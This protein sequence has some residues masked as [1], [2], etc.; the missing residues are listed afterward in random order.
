MED[1]MFKLRFKDIFEYNEGSIYSVNKK[2]L[3]P[4][5][6]E[7]IRFSDNNYLADTKYIINTIE[8]M[9][10]YF[11]SD[12]Y[13]PEKYAKYR[14]NFLQCKK[15]CPKGFIF[16]MLKYF[17]VLMDGHMSVMP[18]GNYELDIN[19]DYNNNKL[20]FKNSNIILFEIGGISSDYLLEKVYEYFYFENKSSKELYIPEYVK[21]KIFLE[22]LGCNIVNNEISI[23]TSDGLKTYSFV[24][25]RYIPNK[26]VINSSIIGNVLYIDYRSCVLNNEFKNIINKIKTSIKNDINKVIIDVRN[27]IGGTAKANHE[28]FKALNMC[29]PFGGSLIRL[30]NPIKERFYNDYKFDTVKNNE[31][32]YT[33][34]KSN[35]KSVRR[36]NKIQLVVLVSKKTYSSAMLFALDVMDGNL[37]KVIGEIPSNAPCSFGEIYLAQTPRLKVPFNI[38]YKYLF[39]PNLRESFKELKP[40]IECA[41][42]KAL[43][44]ALSYLNN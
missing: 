16:E 12:Y 3:I 30:S 33:F 36:N 5:N 40:Y 17:K 38:S 27:N 14:K 19:I 42:S 13:D 21:N 7:V 23:T 24:N 39:R 1:F 34:Y 25:K 43:E 10:P 29:E 4:F 20:Y 28:I 18:L 32:N 41:D 15:I 35:L 22:Y 6:K 2:D 31:I 44:E 8:D 11:I 26:N 37:G 9:H